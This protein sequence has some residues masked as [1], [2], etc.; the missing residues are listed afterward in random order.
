M[1][2]GGGGEEGRGEEGRRRGK[3]GGD[4]PPFVSGCFLLSFPSSSAF[5][6]LSLSSFSSHLPHKKANN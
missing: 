5:F 1:E 2:V 4:G 3:G 6:P